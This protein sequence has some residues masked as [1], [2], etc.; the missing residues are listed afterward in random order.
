MNL[1]T[2]EL[3]LER[4][5]DKLSG[6]DL[7]GALMDGNKERYKAEQQAE[8]SVKRCIK[9]CGARCLNKPS[10]LEKIYRDLSIYVLHDNADH[11]LA[12]IGRGLLDLPVDNAFFKLKV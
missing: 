11:V 4:V 3:W 10:R 6:G 7:A 8:D 12:T 9:I 2:V 1:D 5:A